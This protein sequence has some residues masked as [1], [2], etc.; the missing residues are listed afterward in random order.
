MNLEIQLEDQW[1]KGYR[2]HNALA[3]GMGVENDLQGG[4]NCV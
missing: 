2:T 1:S 3:L 4:H